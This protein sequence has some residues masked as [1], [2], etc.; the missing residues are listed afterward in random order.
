MQLCILYIKF[1]ALYIVCPTIRTQNLN[2]V[3]YTE[4]GIQ[5]YAEDGSNM[6]WFYLRRNRI[7]YPEAAVLCNNLTGNPF[8]NYSK[9]DQNS[10][11]MARLDCDVGDVE[12]SQCDIAIQMDRTD[13][14]N[15]TCLSMDGWSEGDIRQ[16][17]DGRVL[18]LIKPPNSE[19]LVWAHFCFRG[20]DWDENTANLLCR[21]LGYENVKAGGER[22]RFR[23]NLLVFGLDNFKCES[24]VSSYINCTYQPR[25][26]A[27]TCDRNQVIQIECEN[28]I[29]SAST[30]ITLPNNTT[31]TTNA[32][33][34]SPSLTTGSNTTTGPSSTTGL[35][36]TTGPSSTTGLKSTTGPN[37]NI[38]PS[39]ITES[40][41]DAASSST[42]PSTNSMTPT[43]SQSSTES[44]EINGDTTTQ[45]STKTNLIITAI[46]TPLSNIS[47]VDALGGNGG[48][49]IPLLAV[50]AILFILMGVITVVIIVTIIIKRKRSKRES[51]LFRNSRQAFSLETVNNG[52]SQLNEPSYAEIGFLG[53]SMGKPSDYLNPSEI[54]NIAENFTDSN[55]YTFQQD[56]NIYDSVLNRH[57]QFVLA[58]EER[59]YAAD[60]YG[61]A[62]PAYHA[63]ENEI[64]GDTSFNEDEYWEPGATMESIY[65]QMSQYRYRE[66]QR[67]ELVEEGMLGEGNFGLVMSGHWNT[68]GE[69]IPVAI[70]NL[71][72]EDD[73][74]NIQ[75]L[76][77]AAILGQFQHGNVLRLLGVVTISK[78]LLMVTEQMKT[79]LKDFLQSLKQLKT[80]DFDFFSTLFLKFTND[81]ANGM[82]HLASKKFVHRD[83][84]ARNI[85]LSHNL[86]C[87]I[88]D[89]GLA[90]HAIENDEYYTSSGGKIPLKW[91]APEAIFYKKYSE[92]SDVWSYG[93]TIHEL[94]AVGAVP[95]EGV[96]PD[97]VSLNPS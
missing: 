10:M 41:S 75:F 32:T 67:S 11:T 28:I 73:T 6:K 35:K 13:R 34:T 95:W 85:L 1:I 68:S 26:S 52:E 97:D 22:I 27:G 46:T 64:Y 16:L 36:T 89:F 55:H 42:S 65:H 57:N 29:T 17:P 48:I 81:I 14:V 94:W 58:S 92:K 74:S 93:V 86:A 33:A 8:V 51:T 61:L 53:I 30:T 59:D 71:K 12:V 15:V 7:Q 4:T 96:K 47:R 38:G 45:H 2:D 82:Q 21:G 91:T 44:N 18:Y 5:I 31:T 9:N 24:Q 25:G 69:S 63:I 79:G 87:K 88:S 84:A 39:S 72:I 56:E 77:E 76:Q 62:N 50:L 3:R 40:T 49:L 23:P 83:L 90:R 54:E 78:P 19:L 20:N 66:I 70:K 60:T 80:M 43:A 37:T